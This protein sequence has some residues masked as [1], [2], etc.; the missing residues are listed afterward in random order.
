[1]SSTL[2]P[3]EVAPLQS[4]GEL[5]GFLLVGRWPTS[6]LEWMRVLTLAVRVAAMPSMLPTTT[7]FR[8]LENVPTEPPI[9]AVGVLLAEGT[10]TGSDALMP[11]QFADPQ[12]PGLMVLH[13]PAETQPSLPEVSE[14]ASGCVL[15]PG[16]PYL[17]LEHRASWVQATSEGTVTSMVSRS[18]VDPE[19]DADTAVLAML[20]A[21]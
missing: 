10:L 1:M 13:P 9:G 11:G 16:L 17:G 7:V 14:V 12:P 18:G 5:C 3:V 4:H 20:M 2:S 6:T 8:V 19:D 15:L 21:A